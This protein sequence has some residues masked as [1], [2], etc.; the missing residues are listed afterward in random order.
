MHIKLIFYLIVSIGFSCSHAGSYDDFFS[1]IDRDSVQSIGALLDRGFDPNTP[2]PNGEP[3]LFVALRKPSLSVVELLLQ[4]SQ[5]VVDVLNQHGESPL[6]LAALGGYEQICQR[7]IAR[8]ADVNKP[9][10]T[11]LH[12]AATG[13]HV[14]IIQ[15][16]LDAH[17]YIDAASPNGSTPLMM[18][19]RYGTVDAVKRLLNAGADPTL[20]NDLGLTAV[21][22]ALAAEKTESTSV[23]ASSIRSRRPKDKW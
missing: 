13:G 21:D 8:Q 2:A 17:A 23:I 20:K 6:M 16:L 15:M 5:T 7:L 1:A 3:A 22:F 12:Y 14:A 19:A 11:A 9:G 4:R 18:A 10:W